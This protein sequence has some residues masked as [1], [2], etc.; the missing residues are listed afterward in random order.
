MRKSWVDSWLF[1]LEKKRCR[2]QQLR[3]SLFGAKI[4]RLKKS[5]FFL[6]T[7]VDGQV[8]FALRSRR[9]R[10]AVALVKNDLELPSLLMHLY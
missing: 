3:W 6:K 2:R 8:L 7:S 5:L 4:A 10:Y 9:E 1:F